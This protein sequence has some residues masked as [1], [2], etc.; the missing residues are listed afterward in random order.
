MPPIFSTP[1]PLPPDPDVR[2]LITPIGIGVPPL[3]G[4]AAFAVAY[5][6]SILPGVGA[7]QIQ[8]VMTNLAFTPTDPTGGFAIT[9]WR[10]QG[11]QAQ[12]P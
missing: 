9:I 3:S 5:E 4:I 8:V 6:T 1:G 7:T 12:V 10:G 2:T 11:L